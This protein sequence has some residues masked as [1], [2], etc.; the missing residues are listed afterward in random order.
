MA[1][2]KPGLPGEPS[3]GWAANVPAP[4]GAGSMAK[5]PGQE[6][7]NTKKR[8]CSRMGHTDTKKNPLTLH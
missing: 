5:G 2:I 1:V 3:A 4:A 8:H 6:H 7:T